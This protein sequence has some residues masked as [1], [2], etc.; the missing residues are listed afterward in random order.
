[1]YIT[2]KY[3]S[4]CTEVLYVLSFYILIMGLW[5]FEGPGRW[6]S[7]STDESHAGGV[8]ERPQTV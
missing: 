2:Q 3:S 8:R 6:T 7:S 1:M 5:E 4:I